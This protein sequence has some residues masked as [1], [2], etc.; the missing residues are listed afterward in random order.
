[1]TFSDA[2]KWIKGQIKDNKLKE[3]RSVY[4]KGNVFT[5][6]VF[7]KFIVRGFAR[8]EG[9]RQRRKQLIL[10]SGASNPDSMYRC[11][12]LK[13]RLAIED[14]IEWRELVERSE[15]KMLMERGE[16]PLKK[17]AEN[18]GTDQGQG[19]KGH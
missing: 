3:L 18:K 13:H 9:P 6:I 17:V 12:P 14:W 19:K 8:S 11:K 10:L 7:A 15:F 1:M 4:H 5:G 2:E 16:D